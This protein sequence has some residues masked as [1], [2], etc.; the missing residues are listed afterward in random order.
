MLIYAGIRKKVKERNKLMNSNEKKYRRSPLTVACYVLAAL[1]LVYI[2]IQA[3]ATIASMNQYYAQYDMKPPFTEYITYVVQSAARPLVDAVIF[4]MLGYILNEVRKNNRAYYLSD[5]E[6][7]AAKIAKFE[8]REAKKAAAAEAAAAKKADALISETS[9]EDDFA[10]SLDAELKADAKKAPR[11][12]SGGQSRQSGS[13]G[14]QSK[15]KEQ[16]AQ[17]DQKEKKDQ[18]KPKDQKDQKDQKDNK[19]NKE[20]GNKGK[21]KSEGSSSKSGSKGGKKSSSE[22]KAEGTSEKNASE[23]DGSSK[24]SGNGGQRR[25]RKPASDKAKA[26]A[27]IKAES[28]ADAKEAKK[29]EAAAAE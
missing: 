18:K 4:F 22:A 12:K 27:E 29:E 7:E 3:I 17:K 1:M 13:K 8:A 15:A 5:A 28:K 20:S 16:N 25:R 14:G 21:R 24:K 23:K 2:C 6:I 26:D 10:K 19:D 9:V 11:K